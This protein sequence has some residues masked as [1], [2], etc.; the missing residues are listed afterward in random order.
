MEE[1]KVQEITLSPEGRRPLRLTYFI[2]KDGD[3]TPARYGIKIVEGR[4]GEAA[5]VMDLTADPARVRDLAD[6]LVRN[7]V[8]P[9]GLMDVV[10]D[11]L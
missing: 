5:R 2:L 8:T 3:R 7:A 6:K 11:W 9:T 4:G 10:A 1:I